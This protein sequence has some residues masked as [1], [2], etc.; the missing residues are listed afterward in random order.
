MGQRVPLGQHCDKNAA[1]SRYFISVYEQA[2]LGVM[3]IRLEML[4]QLWRVFV[5]YSIGA[6]QAYGIQ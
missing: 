3:A 4:T 6:R 1:V 2:K 5:L